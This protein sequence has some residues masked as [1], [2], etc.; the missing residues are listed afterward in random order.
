MITND[1]RSGAAVVD[2]R[3]ILFILTFQSICLILITLFCIWVTAYGYPFIDG[4]AVQLKNG[5]ILELRGFLTREI[6]SFK[7]NLTEQ[8]AQQLETSLL[9]LTKG[10]GEYLEPYE[11]L[12]T[13]N[14]DELNEAIKKVNR[15]PF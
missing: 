7:S 3:I 4:G 14:V 9:S 13:I 10:V 11:A 12:K 5:L 1:T 2:R 15:L 8:F 6:D